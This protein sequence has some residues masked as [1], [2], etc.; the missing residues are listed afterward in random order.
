MG[1]RLSE[2]TGLNVRK[3]IEARAGETAQ[4]FIYR[5]TAHYCLRM[6][7]YENFSESFYFL[8]GFCL[9]IQSVFIYTNLNN[10]D[11]QTN[12]QLIKPIFCRA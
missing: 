8:K 3:A 9:N 12:Y 1:A 5:N 10:I 6:C 2:A 11:S 4:Q 7:F